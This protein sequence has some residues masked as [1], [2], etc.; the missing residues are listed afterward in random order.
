MAWEVGKEYAMKNKGSARFLGRI[1]NPQTPCV[2]A[3]RTGLATPEQAWLYDEGGYYAAQRNASYAQYRIVSDDPTE[4]EEHLL[5][6]LQEF[7]KGGGADTKQALGFI[8]RLN[9]E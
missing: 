8:R 3:V 2:F 1:D 4:E 9:G 6:Q 7:V 5:K